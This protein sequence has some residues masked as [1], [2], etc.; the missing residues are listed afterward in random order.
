MLLIILAI[1]L[2]LIGLLYTPSK[3]EHAYNAQFGDTGEYF[4]HFNKGYTFG[5][6][7][8]TREQSFTHLGLF[9]PTGTGKSS[10]VCIPTIMRLCSGNNSLVINDTK[11]AELYTKCS[12]FIA[13]RQ[14]VRYFNFAD[15]LHSE[16]FNFL[17]QPNL[18]F[19]DLKK[20]AH[21]L[22]FNDREAGKQSD[23]FWEQ[24]VTMMLSLFMRYVVFHEE[25]KYRTMQNV[26]RLIEKFA[27][28]PKAIDKL[29]VRTADEDLLDQ[30]KAL[31]TV[32]ER[33]LQSIII[34]ARV[35][36]DIWHD[37]HVCR[38][39]ATSSFDLST[40]RQNPTSVFLCNPLQDVQ[41][42]K[43]I[44]ALFFQTL[45]NIALS[46]TPSKNE[47]AIFYILEEAATMSFPQLS[48]T[49]AQARAF[50]A[51]FLIAMQDEES[52]VSQYGQHEAHAIKSNFGTL[53]YLRS[54]PLSTCKDLSAM[55]GKYSYTD[56]HGN[57][58]TR[59]LMT[60]DEL[61]QTQDAIVIVNAIPLKIRPIPYYENAWQRYRLN[62]PSVP[63][64]T[65]QL[66]DLPLISFK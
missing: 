44:S 30:Y 64:P 38:T 35:M 27:V 18:S 12:G 31:V 15:S 8:I 49:I 24:S 62:C 26:L 63:L 50:K 57:T 28:D 36:L 46:R 61:R 56:E 3:K 40:I 9:S 43:G 60:V 4:S 37:E 59:E 65:N 14:P 25:H 41:Y 47:C 7:S 45:F 48:N 20:Y 22:T 2:I 54:A 66:I 23:P 58:K 19:S 10:I 16:S 17:H 1:V 6:I 42:F 11:G 33:T 55:L 53:A 21:I 32:P 39:T 34:S 13:K 29:M 5:N 51:S 52:L